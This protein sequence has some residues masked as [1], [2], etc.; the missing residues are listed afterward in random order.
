[1]TGWTAAGASTGAILSPY[2]PNNL[3]LWWA[4]NIRVL[5]RDPRFFVRYQD[6]H[7]SVLFLAD[8]YGTRW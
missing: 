1:M 3:Y 7:A 4:Q 5:G 8:G 2:V 6:R